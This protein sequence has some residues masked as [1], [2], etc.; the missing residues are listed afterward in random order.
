MVE[1]RGHPVVDDP[2]EHIQGGPL[3]RVLGDGAKTDAKLRL[4]I[5][6]VKAAAL[7]PGVGVPRPSHTM[8]RTAPS[9]RVMRKVSSC[10]AEFTTSVYRG[11][12]ATAFVL[13]G[14]RVGTG[15]APPIGHSL[16]RTQ[17]MPPSPSHKECR[18]SRRSQ[19]PALFVSLL[20]SET[21]NKESSLSPRSRFARAH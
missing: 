16:S 11:D 5:E 15:Y 4:T 13:V 8:Q 12:R 1:P 21:K 20:R 10:P 14:R 19:I 6:I 9:R 18:A 3:I 7:H 2:H 17:R